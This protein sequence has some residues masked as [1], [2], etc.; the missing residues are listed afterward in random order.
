MAVRY[1]KEFSNSMLGTSAS[2]A[3][4]ERGPA[5]VAAFGRDEAKEALSISD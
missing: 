3:S 5:F 4:L 1:S 2:G